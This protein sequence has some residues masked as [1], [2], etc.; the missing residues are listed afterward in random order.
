MAA[1]TVVSLVVLWVD[2]TD[3]VRVELMAALLVD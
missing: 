2:R 3:I 1:R